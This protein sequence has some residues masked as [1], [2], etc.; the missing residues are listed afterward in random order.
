M[1]T[2]TYFG[3]SAFR[4]RGKK[5][6]ILTDPYGKDVFGRLFPKVEAD[7][8]TVSHE[9]ADHNAVDR[10]DGDPFIV[11]QPGEY[12]IKGA[13]ILG[14]AS[15]HDAVEGAKRGQNTICSI[16][17]DGVRICHLGDLGHRLSDKQQEEINGVDV[18]MV[19]VGGVYTL[20]AKKAAEVVAQVEPNIV[21]PMHYQLP[22]LKIKLGSL[23]K[24][25][26]EM[27]EKSPQKMAVLKLEREKIE[28]E[29]K[30][31]VLDARG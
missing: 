19:P 18:L 13:F 25:L 26:E 8:V 14:I 9:H 1:V 28:E 12:E 29:R 10:V 11:N 7:V 22:D 23:S 17:I 5:T 6:S 24:F 2:I 31:V 3:H 20:D 15:F 4:I 21:L 30:V 27:G 16:E